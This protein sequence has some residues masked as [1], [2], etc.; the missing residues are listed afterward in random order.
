MKLEEFRTGN[1]GEFKPSSSN[2]P[3]TGSVLESDN[4]AG[5][6]AVVLGET[7]SMDP[8]VIY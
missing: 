4:L 5:W 8:G 7:N 3:R 2:K 6:E 1:F